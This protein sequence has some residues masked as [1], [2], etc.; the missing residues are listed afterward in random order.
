MYIVA[1]G[2]LYVVLMMAL[3]ENNVVAGI[4]TFFWYGLI[5][6]A[7]LL[8]LVGVPRRKRSGVAAEEDTGEP[9][10]GDPQS[11]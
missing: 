2:W 6:L 5:P 1:I 7:L 11:D 10:R 4:M 9:D 3:S 8:W